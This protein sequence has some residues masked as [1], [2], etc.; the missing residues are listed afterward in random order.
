MRKIFYLILASITASNTAFGQFVISTDASYASQTSNETNIFGGT[1]D[2]KS[3]GYAIMPSIRYEFSGDLLAV[4]IGVYGMY[5]NLFPV[6]TGYNSDVFTAIGYGGD[7]WLTLMAR[8]PIKPF[9][10][11][12]LGRV[13]L[14]DRV[15]ATTTAGTYDIAVTAAALHVQAFGG[16]RIPLFSKL[17][18]YLQVGYSGM[19]EHSP[20]LES[21]TLNGKP[22]NTVVVATKSAYSTGYLAGGGILFKF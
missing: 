21:A 1:R 18:F 10:R 2:V 9:A 22:T 14:K 11:F 6:N 7:L 12:T 3:N 4:A 8:L 19:A 5:G 16:V 15:T 17:E 20:V 13:S